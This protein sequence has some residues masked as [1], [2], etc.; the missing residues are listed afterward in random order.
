MSPT[1]TFT[2][3]R[4]LWRVQLASQEVIRQ[5]YKN[6][7]NKWPARLLDVVCV[8]EL[9]LILIDDRLTSDKRVATI[10]HELI[11]AFCPEMEEKKV[12]QLERLIQSAGEFV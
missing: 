4:K 7:H 6:G 2:I 8:Y 3:D 5:A 12:M 1:K 9:R 11:H 10:R